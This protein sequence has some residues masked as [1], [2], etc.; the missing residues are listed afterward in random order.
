VSGEDSRRTAGK[1]ERGRLPRR[2]RSPGTAR[3]SFI[4]AAGLPVDSAS[5]LIGFVRRRGETRVPLCSPFSAVGE[6]ISLA[7]NRFYCQRRDLTADDVVRVCIPYYT[8]IAVVQPDDSV[9]PPYPCL[10]GQRH[11]TIS[12]STVGC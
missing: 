9:A 3:T 4:S 1:R 10:V 2:A 12:T 5:D 11:V 6:S 8:A 7:L